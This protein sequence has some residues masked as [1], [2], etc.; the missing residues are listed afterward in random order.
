MTK[1]K[2][3]NP[4]HRVRSGDYRIVYEINE[5]SKRIIILKIGHRKEI[6]DRLKNLNP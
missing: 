1:M 5:A 2:G 6:Y 4:F 3:E